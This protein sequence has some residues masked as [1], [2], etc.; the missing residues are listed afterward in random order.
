[1]KK[2]V[3]TFILILSMLFVMGVGGLTV[4]AEDYSSVS[5]GA[6]YPRLTNCNQ[7]T[8]TFQVIDPGEA[9]VLTTY[10]A[11]TDVFTQAKLTAKIQKKFLGLFWT[12]VDIG[13]ANN[14]WIAYSNAINGRF[15][16]YFNVDGTGTYR[17]VF[18]LEI[19]GTS[20]AVDTIEDTIEF[21]YN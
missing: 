9:H 1:M 3:L 20:G 21:K 2:R 16:N 18:Y 4:S 12:T 11:K 10:S 15:Y 6:I 19:Y 7:C 17:A 8:F 14:E 13:T 5:E